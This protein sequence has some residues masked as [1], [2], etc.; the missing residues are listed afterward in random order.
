VTHPKYTLEKDIIF[1][2]RSSLLNRNDEK[3]KEKKLNVTS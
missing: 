1:N 2:S 3:I